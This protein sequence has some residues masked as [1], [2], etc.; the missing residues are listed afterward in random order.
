SHAV[1]AV[2]V[3]LHLL[4]AH[5]EMLTELGLRHL[6]GEA[7]DANVAADHAIDLLRALLLHTPG[8]LSRPRLP[9]SLMPC[10]ACD[11]LRRV[12]RRVKD[13]YAAL[14]PRPPACA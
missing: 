5:P 11:G 8:P 3:L 4:E 12:A 13:I 7:V 2:L 6:L 9:R 10:L 1:D 14:R